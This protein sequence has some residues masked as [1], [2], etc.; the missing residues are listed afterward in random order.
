[1]GEGLVPMARID[2]AVRRIPG[3]SRRR[4]ASSTTPPPQPDL[5]DCVGCAAHRAT[6]RA[7]VRKSLVLL[8]NER[9]R[10]RCAPPRRSWWRGAAPTTSGCSA[11][12]G[13]WSGSASAAT[14]RPRAPRSTTAC[15]P[16]ARAPSSSR[17]ARR[18]RRPPP[19]PSP[20]RRRRG[21]VR[22]GGRRHPRPHARRRRR[23]AHRRAA[24]P[25]GRAQARLR[26]ALRPPARA[27]AAAPRE[28]RRARRRL[29]PGTEGA[30]VADVLFGDA[31]FEGRLSFSWPRDNAQARRE[32]ARGGPAVPAGVWAVMP[33]VISEDSSDTSLRR[34][35][36]ARRRWAGRSAGAQNAS[37]RSG[38]SSSTV[39]RGDI[40]KRGP[41]G[42]GEKWGAAHPVAA[43][44]GGARRVGGEDEAVEVADLVRGFV[45]KCWPLRGVTERKEAERR[46]GSKGVATP[47]PRPRTLH[48]VLDDERLCAPARV[49]VA[50]PGRFGA[51]RRRGRVPRP[52]RVRLEAE[53]VADGRR[54]ARRPALA[55]LAVQRRDRAQLRRAVVN[56]RSP[57]RKSRRGAFPSAAATR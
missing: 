45:E 43:G 34:G 14:R 54:A 22:R 8:R 44:G 28:A 19:R 36:G 18:R 39:G 20:R 7:A 41:L 5:D 17:T 15:A 32:R 40:D 35:C 9:R 53:R 51:A 23:R 52:R 29:A 37:G 55:R 57:R 56:F 4:C 2:D 10:C 21:A 38:A 24:R 27:A 12:A 49:V 46:S 25:D 1:M 42:V 47:P 33:C 11:A 31:P 3:A 26:A 6:A 50:R 48:V 16:R 30:G 13:R